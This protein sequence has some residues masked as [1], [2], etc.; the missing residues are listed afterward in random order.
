MTS[1]R[2]L[3]GS[4]KIGRPP[5][6]RKGSIQRAVRYMRKNATRR[7]STS[8]LCAVTGLSERTL[9]YVFEREFKI[10]PVRMARRLRLELAH[11]VLLSANPANTSV[12]QVAQRFGFDDLPLFSL[13]YSKTFNEPPSR[14]LRARPTPRLSRFVVGRS[15]RA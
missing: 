14:T 11:K 13:T 7:I 10:S 9:R 6:P 1:L 3:K 2:N 15:A 5:M 12:S 8:E 4:R